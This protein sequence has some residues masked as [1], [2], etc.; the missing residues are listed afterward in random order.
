MELEDMDVPKQDILIYDENESFF[1][2]DNLRHQDVSPVLIANILYKLCDP[3][4]PF[5][6]EN[7]VKL[8]NFT[9]DKLIYESPLNEILRSFDCVEFNKK[10]F[11]NFQLDYSRFFHF[12][13][14]LCASDKQGYDILGLAFFSKPWKHNA[15][16]QLEFIK[17]CIRTNNVAMILSSCHNASLPLN[18]IV[19]Q[20]DQLKCQPD[21]EGDVQLQSWKYQC[22]YQILVDLSESSLLQPF[23]EE[24]LFYPLNKCPDLLVLGLL[25]CYGNHTR[26]K[27][28]VLMKAILKFLYPT[29]SHPNSTQIFQRI[30]P[31]EYNHSS[32]A[33]TSSQRLLL[34]AMIELYTTSSPEEQQQ[35]LSRILDLSQDLKALNLLLSS[36]SQLFVIDLACLASRREYLKLDKWLND[37]IHS[38]GQ[39]FIEACLSFLKRRCPAFGL[40]EMNAGTFPNE[41][42]S[43]ILTCLRQYIADN[44]KNLVEFEIMKMFAKYSQWIA[45][46]QFLN[47]A[48]TTQFDTNM[49]GMNMA[50]P[51]S[52]SPLVN[53]IRGPIGSGDSVPPANNQLNVMNVQ[54]F[55]PNIGQEFSKEIEEEAD[56][57]FQKIYNQDQPDSLS[58][59]QVLEMLKKFQESQNKREK[60]VFACMIRNLFKEYPFLNQYPDKE[61]VITGEIFG[62]IILYDFVKGFSFVGALRY[63]LE[64][65]K[66]PVNSR[67]FTFGQAALNKFKTRLK[68]FPQF[69]QHIHDIGHFN[70]FPPILIEYIEIGRKTGEQSAAAAAAAATTNGA[71]F[72]TA[73]NNNMYGNSKKIQQQMTNN[74]GPSNNGN[75]SN[76]IS[77]NSS[78]S[79]NNNNV[80]YLN[81]NNNKSNMMLFTNSSEPIP[82]S[83][84]PEI[85]PPNTFQDKV[86]FI[87]NNL[88]AINLTKKTEEFKELFTKEKEQYHQWISQYFVM[89][90]VSLESNF[91]ELYANFVVK[92]AINDLTKLVLQET[93]RNIK[94]LLQS[95]KE[96]D[97]F[98]DRTLLKNL[99]QWLGLITIGQN[100]PVLS[101]DLDLRNL[102]IEAYHKG[103]QQLMYVVPFVAK[104]IS[105][106]SKSK[107]FRPPN[108]WTDSLISILVEL[109]SEPDLKL[110]LKFEVEVLCKNLELDINVYMGKSNILKNKELFAKIEPQLSVAALTH[111]TPPTMVP[112]VPETVMTL[113]TTSPPVPLTANM[114]HR[115]SPS[116]AGVTNHSGSTRLFN[117]SDVNISNISNLTNSLVF[118]PNNL[119][120][121]NP[122]LKTIMK[123]LIEKTVH[124]WIAYITDRLIN[125]PMVT[126][127]TLIKKDFAKEPNPEMIRMAAQS[128]LKALIAG[129]SLI[130]TKESLSLRLHMAIQTLFTTKFN[131]NFP[132]DT[133][134]AF[135]TSIIND[136]IDVCVAFVQKNSIERGLE[137]LDKKLKT[138]FDMGSYQNDKSSKN[139]GTISMKQMLVYE[140]MGRNMPGFFSLPMDG[141]KNIGSATSTVSANIPNYSI[142]QNEQLSSGGGGAQPSVQ[143]NTQ[144]Q[145]QQAPPPPPVMDNL[146]LIYD[147]LINQLAELIQEFEYVHFNTE[148]M[149]Q[150]L[151]ILRVLKTNP[152]EQSTVIHLIKKR[153]ECITVTD[154]S[155]VSR[156][157]EYY[158]ILLKA[159]TDQRAFNVRFTTT[160]ITRSVMEHWIIS[161]QQFPDEL[162]DTLSRSSFI[163]FAYMD[164]EF[165]QF[166][167]SGQSTMAINIILNFLKCYLS[168]G[169]ASNFFT[170]TLELLQRIAMKVNQSNHPLLTD[171]K[172]ILNLARINQTEIMDTPSLIEK[173]DSIIKDWIS[174]FNSSKTPL[175][176]SFSFMVKNMSAQGL[177]KNDELISR[178]FKIFLELC[179]ERCYQVFAFAAQHSNVSL[180]EVHNKCFEY[181]DAFSVLVMQFI[182]Q[183]GNQGNI[184]QKFQFLNKILNI[185]VTTANKDQE[186][187]HQDFLPL[188]YYR[189]LILIFVDFFYCPNNFGIQEYMYHD[190]FFEAF[191]MHIVR[192]YCNLLRF[193][194]PLKFNLKAWNNYFVLLTDLLTFKKPILQNIEL[195]STNNELY[196][197]TLKL[198][199]LLLH[200]FP[201]FLSEYAHNLC[202][203]VPFKAIQLRNIILSAMPASSGPLPE[204][205][206]MVKLESLA[207]MVQPNRNNISLQ[208]GESIQFR[209][210]LDS[211]LLNRSPVSFL[212]ELRGALISFNPDKQIS[213][214]IQQIN[215]LVVYIGNTATQKFYEQNKNIT[216]NSVNSAP[217]NDIFKSLFMS[218]DSQGR[219]ILLNMMVDHLRYPTTDTLFFMCTL[220][221]LFSDSNEHV[222]EQIVRVLL[223]RLIAMRPHPW[224]LMFTVNELIRN[225]NYKLLDHTFIKCIPEVEKILG[226]LFQGVLSSIGLI[227]NQNSMNCN[228]VILV[229]PN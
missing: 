96:T 34:A 16:F 12:C 7:L 17:F 170:N 215:A 128:M 205:L 210:E 74:N 79:N 26:L 195:T 222:R 20:I 226:N 198:F 189:I 138:D 6:E 57:Y 92:L 181:I 58:I 25:E 51:F 122:Q 126:T 69:C 95:N 149:V 3:K 204:P 100:K 105:G 208:Y 62:G 196:K 113:Q 72:G 99:G 85:V 87:I 185:L 31:T 129:F 14:I 104:V 164:N 77:L 191:K 82:N 135:A 221:S 158:L 154:F 175:S 224:G 147:K 199:L 216:I 89:K 118:Q 65:L 64:S 137:E 94:I 15:Y 117:Y 98:N 81:N 143:N 76:Q 219:H 19:P 203:L 61:L 212:G 116:L 214:N 184:D 172:N 18:K 174:N 145:Q 13:R 44:P 156:V 83:S 162:F 167:E 213:Y 211:Y 182:K 71:M 80:N 75:N 59:D 90:R 30:W 131:K 86:A 132:K 55:V 223:E 228:D 27:E 35:K 49:M 144:Q 91:H 73:G 130:S 139:N 54:L 47:P 225:P 36:N 68:E 176:S 190:G 109:H 40:N 114:I 218:F 50:Q 8:A 119:I 124:E 102:L 152:R 9:V 173:V 165:F 217:F 33:L 23:L 136:N 188:P 202:E 97:N 178:F 180:N 115:L 78:S 142:V 56:S 28:L 160:N 2:L 46:S 200:D 146:V 150:V 110:N 29:S 10:L 193:L 32:Q 159:L 141:Y 70:E 106:C 107:I 194:S 168:N 197:G 209:K 207:E 37:K 1:S 39:P 163:N 38:I 157:R 53:V 133:I 166:L 63:V 134:D 153:C 4:L 140:E 48:K 206:G 151:E 108:P 179:V 42:F 201:D 41:T 45:Q 125:V 161:N 111:Q 120:L 93:Y 177:L 103:L 227:S 21:Y 43:T 112:M 67:Y 183:S 66:K 229:D 186:I 123:G 220:L 84:S 5:L 148:P 121:A 155:S 127:E 187:R 171:L 192:S 52:E 88:S 60:E 101:I 169:I 24:I 22:L 11:K